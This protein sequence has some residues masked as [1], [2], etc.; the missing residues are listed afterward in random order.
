MAKD[1]VKGVTDEIHGEDADSETPS[2]FRASRETECGQAAAC[3]DCCHEGDR[4]R[5]EFL[6]FSPRIRPQSPDRF[7]HAAGKR[8]REHDDAANQRARRKEDDEQDDAE[9]AM[10]SVHA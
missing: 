3:S 9:R 8:E 7:E 1:G 5:A 2:P 10:H 4:P 6:K